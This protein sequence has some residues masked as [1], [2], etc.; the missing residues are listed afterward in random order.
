MIL[1]RTHRGIYHSFASI[2]AECEVGKPPI[3]PKTGAQFPAGAREHLVVASITN[4]AMI[5]GYSGLVHLEGICLAQLN[6]NI[7]SQH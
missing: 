3:Y 2:L 7:A 4:R 5:V 1:M 6:Q